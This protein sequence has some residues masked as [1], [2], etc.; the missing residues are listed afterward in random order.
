MPQNPE[1]LR[2]L[3]I[4]RSWARALM[5]AGAVD[6]VQWPYRSLPNPFEERHASL[7][8]LEALV[9]ESVAAPA[10]QPLR[11]VLEATQPQPAWPT[12]SWQ[13]RPRRRQLSP[14]TPKTQSGPPQ[15]VERSEP[16]WC[17]RW[18]ETRGRWCEDPGRLPNS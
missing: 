17:E 16:K 12:G 5:L 15:L 18:C 6:S 10:A 14:S 7:R 13:W 11:L 4:S 3:G 2:T 8:G 9:A 1:H